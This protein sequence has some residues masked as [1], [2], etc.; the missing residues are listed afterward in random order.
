[1]TEQ[2]NK[3]IF[4]IAGEAS[5]DLH[6]AKLVEELQAL[7]PNISF[8]GLGGA[9]M[10]NVGVD[11]YMD[12]TEIAVV[13]FFEVLKNYN[14]FKRAFDLVLK[15]IKLEKP[16][17]VVLVDYPG[18][19]LRLA[20]KIKKLGIKVIYYI[21]PQVWAWKKNR[22]KLIKKYVDKMLVIFK[23]EKD[24][25][26]LNNVDC[27]FVGHPLIDS[28]N[29]KISKDDFLNQHELDEYKLTI[30]IL[31]GSREK[32]VSLLL[33]VMLSAANII[34]DD[35]PMTQF[36]ILKAECIEKDLIKEYSTN[37]KLNIKIIENQHYDAINS[38]DLC[39]VASGTATLETAILQKPMVVTYKTSFLTWIL[40]KLFVKIP[41]I[42]LVNIV[43]NKK[44][45][46]E[47]IQFDASGENI[48][49]ELK[50]IFTDDMKLEELK[51]ELL[52]VKQTLDLGGA[53]KNAANKILE[54][55]K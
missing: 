28:I 19:N 35:F 13:G 46:P 22:I 49:N 39:M 45:M 51:E 27:D 18:F 36:I 42:G 47:C 37:N 24:F 29:T 48:A 12:L 15:K 32:E 54:V 50:K 17:A 4:I 33:P 34:K 53:S 41:N 16:D 11:L 30:G 8:Y 20:K 23:F 31:P 55:I 7:D 3:K 9:N 43:A 14:T 40:A 44:I 52:K 38:C 21:S 10:R 2:K 1:M 6:A 26:K 25:Y 5:G